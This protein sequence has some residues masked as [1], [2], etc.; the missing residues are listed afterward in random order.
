MHNTEKLVVLELFG[1]LPQ[2]GFEVT[3]EISNEGDRASAKFFGKLPANH[4]LAD[5]IY[6]HWEQEYRPLGI[7]GNYRVLEAKKIR[8]YGSIQSCKESAHRLR[9][10]FLSWLQAEEFQ[11]L[12]TR[13]R[14]FL[15]PEDSIRFLIRSNDAS[16]YKLPWQEW[17]FFQRYPYAGY[18]FSDTQFSNSQ[19]SPA[20]STAAKVRILVI[21]GHDEGIDI[22][23]DRQLFD[24]LPNADVT[25]L[26]QPKRQEIGDRL[27]EQPWDIIFFAGHGSS[28]GDTGKIYINP[29]DSLDIAELWHGLRKAV[30]QGLQVAIFNSCDGLALPQQLDD[31]SI[32]QMIVMRDMIPDQVAHQFLKYFLQSFSEGNSFYL[33][34]REA[35]E[36]LKGLEDELPCASWLPVI[37]QNPTATPPT[38]ESLVGSSSTK[39]TPIAPPKPNK[40]NKRILGSILGGVGL[41]VG[42][43]TA[44]MG[45]SYV[46]QVKAIQKYEADEKKTAKTYLKLALFF[47]PR[48]DAAQGL[49]GNLYEDYAYAVDRAIRKYQEV[50]DQSDNPVACNNLARLYI[51]KGS[52]QQAEHLL[53]AYCMHLTDK[54][55]PGRLY[56]HKNL[57]W[58]FWEQGEY[59]QAENQLRQAMHIDREHV[60]DSN[61]GVYCLL[62]QIMEKEGKTSQETMDFWHLCQE[63]ADPDIPEERKWQQ[64]AREIL[65]WEDSND[66]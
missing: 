61:A 60:E 25:F 21:L 29:E 50:L 11:H 5:F 14:E 31:P 65:A 57:G 56:I 26:R 42:T 15:S 3:L 17:D 13:L 55:S 27:W 48:N 7:P 53:Y 54:D 24:E 20:A 64:Q 6:Y 4:N 58:S 16:L 10:R 30:K 35:K 41:L 45:L 43:I 47:N 28:E 33:A 63:Y 46:F 37:F 66:K 22:K 44:S 8:H 18:S 49:R 59:Q 38:W 52:F 40:R 19:K 39:S 62:A 1:D 12:D 9:D 23:R 51:R 36:R 32:P 34:T 2:R